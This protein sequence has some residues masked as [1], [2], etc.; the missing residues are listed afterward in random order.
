MLLYLFI[1][2]IIIII[3]IT[4]FIIISIIIIIIIFIIIIIIIIYYMMRSVVYMKFTRILFTCYEYG[5]FNKFKWN[6]HAE[7]CKFLQKK[8]PCYLHAQ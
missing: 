2:I 3:V 6:L 8:C 5:S 7:S 1:I 4:I